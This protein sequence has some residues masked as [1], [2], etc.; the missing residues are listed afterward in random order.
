MRKILIQQLLIF[1]S[2]TIVGVEK[3]IDLSVQ[4]ISQIK[5]ISSNVLASVMIHSDARRELD[6]SS[7]CVQVTLGSE[8]RTVTFLLVLH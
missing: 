4:L 2:E 6:V 5:E 3:N 1:I 8:C 7:R